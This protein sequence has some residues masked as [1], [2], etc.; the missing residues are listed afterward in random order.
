MICDEKQSLPKPIEQH[1]KEAYPY[2]HG[3]RTKIC[4][5]LAWEH[6]EV[7]KNYRLC[8][9]SEE[10]DIITYS[11]D[12]DR[13]YQDEVPSKILLKK[14]LIETDLSTRLR[15]AQHLLP[16]LDSFKEHI[17]SSRIWIEEGAGA[18]PF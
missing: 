14:P 2:V 17:R 11:V 15:Y 10:N 5:Y 1:H 16:F 7:S 18:I 9:V 4:W 12:E 3:Y 6:E 8:L 13:V